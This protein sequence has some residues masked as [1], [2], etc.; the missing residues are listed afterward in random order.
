MTRWYSEKKREHYY[1]Q[2]KQQGYRARSAYK[3]K[4]IQ[5]KFSVMKPG[6]YVI[7]LG[8]APGGW[9]QIASEIIGSTGKIIAVDLQ[10]MKPLQGVIVIQG[11]MT[12]ED[13]V[14][15]IQQQ[16]KQPY[17]DVV[18]SD[19][20][21]DISGNYTVDQA[22][23][24]WLC[25]HALSTV[26]KLLKPQGHFVCKIFEGEDIASF[27]E[28]L[29]QSFYIVKQFSPKASRKSSSEVY[30]IAMSFHG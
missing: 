22:R 6:D 15:E 14:Q 18:L 7:D 2:A 12:Q 23:S 25:E 21:P 10:E 27:R 9:S 28:K 26:E 8:G 24:V 30:L 4:E 11:D 3:L 13:T 19:M 16:M 17:A 29:R 5:R 20:S 1:K